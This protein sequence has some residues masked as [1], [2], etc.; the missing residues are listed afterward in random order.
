MAWDRFPETK[1]LGH[2]LE[3]WLGMVLYTASSLAI[4]MVLE[5]VE[6]RPGPRFMLA[7]LPLLPMLMMGRGVWRMVQHQDELYKRIQLHALAIASTL[8]VVLSLL[9]GFM[10]GLEVIPHINS[11]WAGQVL[12]FAWGIGAGVLTRRYR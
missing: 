12:I 2:P 3:F 1:W 6:L 8:V 7:V 5:T 10:E 4:T 9:F 11:M